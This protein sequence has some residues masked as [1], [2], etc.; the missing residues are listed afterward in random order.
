MK[1][2]DK[3]NFTSIITQIGKDKL[4]NCYWFQVDP[5]ANV[6]V[7]REDL[8]DETWE[9]VASNRFV[10]SFCNFCNFSSMLILLLPSERS[11]PPWWSC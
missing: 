9:L 1:S 10:L 5:E 11:W 2:K 4:G 3:N 7:Y 8:D 6:R